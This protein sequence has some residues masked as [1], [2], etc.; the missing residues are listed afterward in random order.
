[1]DG[2][3]RMVVG[4]R[5]R[6]WTWMQRYT[7][8]IHHT[9][10]KSIHPARFPLHA[11]LRA[12]ELSRARACVMACGRSSS[13]SPGGQIAGE[14]APPSAEQKTQQRIRG[15]QTAVDCVFV[16]F[17]FVCQKWP[18]LELAAPA[19]SKA[20]KKHDREYVLDKRL[21]IVCL[22]ILCMCDCVSEMAA[23]RAGRAHP[24]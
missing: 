20:F 21:L 12:L 23:S 7:I 3:V 2:M 10:S 24:P 13:V 9:P 22:C 8:Y 4:T 15:R 18:L 1:M 16:R 11:F 6:T 19:A 5:A 14:F 17:V